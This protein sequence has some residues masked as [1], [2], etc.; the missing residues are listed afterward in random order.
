MILEDFYVK[1]LGT[2]NRDSLLWID[3]GGTTYIYSRAANA[4]PIKEIARKF[5][6]LLKYGPGRALAWLK[7]NTEMRGK[8]PT[9]KAKSM[10]KENQYRAITAD[11][12]IEMRIQ[13]RYVK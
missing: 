8:V 13:Q 4:D 11:F 7:K 6:K 2:S 5:E 1:Y 12:L 10:M 3:L 9:D